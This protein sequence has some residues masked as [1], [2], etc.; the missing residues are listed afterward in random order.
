M[1]ITLE[2]FSNSFDFIYAQSR[3][4]HVIPR[5]EEPHHFILI[6][7]HFHIALQYDIKKNPL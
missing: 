1:N 2:S 6:F 3:N 5:N 7:I 4:Q